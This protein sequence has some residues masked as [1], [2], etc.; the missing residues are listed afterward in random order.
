MR[1][2]LL[3]LVLLS[4]CR[5]SEPVAG[6]PDVY[7][8]SGEI[9][10]LNTEKKIAT[11]KHGPIKSTDGKVW[12]EAMTMEFPVRDA[13]GLAKLSPGVKLKAKLYQQPVDFDYWVAEIEVQP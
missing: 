1:Y 11:I 10:K 2:L 12:M 7:Q 4:A 6:P 5:P 3:F 13:V 8:L 9:V